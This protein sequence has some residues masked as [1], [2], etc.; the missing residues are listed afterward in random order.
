MLAWH[1]PYLRWTRLPA[2]VSEFEITHLSIGT[3]RI[4]GV[5][6]VGRGYSRRKTSDWRPNH[7]YSSV[8]VEPSWVF[9]P[10]FETV[11]CWLSLSC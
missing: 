3:V 5:R 1:V 11:P 6:K 8:A 7:G 2:E 10:P 9:T 4:G